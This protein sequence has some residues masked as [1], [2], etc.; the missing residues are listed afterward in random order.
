[1]V[2]IIVTEPDEL[3]TASWSGGITTELFIWPKDGDYLERRFDF[4]ISTAFVELESSTFTKLPGVKRYITPLVKEGFRLVINGNEKKLPLGEV[5]YFSGE[6]DITCY[7]SG[8]DLNLMLKHAKGNMQ[9]IG[10]KKS[11]KLPKS[12]F[13]FIYTVAN[14]TIL[15][16]APIR[17]TAEVGCCAP[18]EL[19]ECTFARLIGDGSF[20][21]SGSIVLISADP[22]E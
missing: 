8:R 22:L 14:T 15:P 5:L 3:N 10:P 7:G 18:V 11:V 20:Y 9:F 6:D 2:R 4:R 13:V 21:T 19:P 17:R 12:E 16:S 1:M